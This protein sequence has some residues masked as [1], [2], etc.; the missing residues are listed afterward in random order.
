VTTSNSCYEA[1]TQRQGRDITNSLEAG[2][3]M[4]LNHPFIELDI[5]N[6]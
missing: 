2:V 1:Y 6:F 4:Y 5:D 3:G